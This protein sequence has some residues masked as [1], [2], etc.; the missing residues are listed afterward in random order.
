MHYTVHT[1]EVIEELIDWIASG[2]T[3]RAFCRQKGKPAW[4]TVYLWLEQDTE[5]A[6]RFASARDLGADAIAEEALSIADTPLVGETVST[7]ARGETVRREDM[8]GHRKLQVDTRLRLLAKW[9]PKKYGEKTE[10][11]VN[12][13]VTLSLKGSDV[14]G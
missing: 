2:Q 11:T 14:T 8:L 1:P 5:L 4:R 7:D 6:A 10:H 9:N 3:L 13:P 12:G